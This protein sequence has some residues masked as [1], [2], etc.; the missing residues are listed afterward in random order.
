MLLKM[1]ALPVPGP[2]ASRMMVPSSMFQSTS[3]SISASSPCALSASIQPR[4]SP[5]A[6]GLRSADMSSLRTWNMRHSIPR[7]PQ[8]RWA[9]SPGVGNASTN[10][11]ACPPPC[12]SAQAGEGT[13]E[14]KSRCSWLWPSSGSNAFALARCD[15]D[16]VD[17]LGIGGAAAEIA[18]QIVPDLL[19][20]RIGMGVEQL[21]RHQHE[22]RR[23]VSALEGAGLDEGLL[24]G[25]EIERLRIRERLDRPHL[26]AVDERGQV[27]AAGNGR[28]VHQHGAA[29]A[30]SLAAALARAHQ[31][32]FALQQLDE[33]V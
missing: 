20:V 14:P 29:A 25:A 8:T 1:S 22:A 9:P 13:Q 17:D 18:G 24:H 12:P 16:R 6:M 23:A 33:V 5:K 21:C 31:I 15:L 30:Q 32:E 2:C 7:G 27:E 26:G 19:L 4:K 28:A 10:L 3:A 11:G